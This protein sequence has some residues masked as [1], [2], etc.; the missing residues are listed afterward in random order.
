MHLTPLLLSSCKRLIPAVYG[1]TKKGVHVQS[2][3]QIE[4]SSTG[5]VQVGED[6]A[7]FSVGPGSRYH[8]CG[9]MKCPSVP[10]Q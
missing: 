5:A 6:A 3:L 9:K 4:R 10:K 7:F 2:D 8:L 1:I